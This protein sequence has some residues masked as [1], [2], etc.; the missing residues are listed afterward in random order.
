MTHPGDLFDLAYLHSMT[1][2][3]PDMRDTLLDL[4]R[5]ELPRERNTLLKAVDDEDVHAIFQASHSL[6]ST[7]AYTGNRQAMDINTRLESATREG[8]WG[9]EEQALVTELVRVIDQL[10]QALPALVQGVE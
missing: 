9:G 4:L 10:V 6:K 8:R 2:G 5:E 1:G 7:L 3:D